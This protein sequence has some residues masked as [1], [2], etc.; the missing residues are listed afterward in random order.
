MEGFIG[1]KREA[2]QLDVFKL[3]NQHYPTT[4]E[5]AILEKSHWTNKNYKISIDSSG[6]IVVKFSHRRLRLNNDLLLI[7]PEDGKTKWKCKSKDNNIYKR[8]FLPAECR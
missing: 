7:K 4:E 1:A 3:E 2:S 5:A 6:N 8:K